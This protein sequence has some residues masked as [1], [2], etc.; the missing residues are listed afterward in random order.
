MVRSGKRRAPLWARLGVAAGCLLLIPAGGTLVAERAVRAGT[1]GPVN[2]LLVGIDPRDEHTAPLADTIIVAHIPANRQGAYLFSLP[3]DLVVH[4]P[5][6]ATN[7]T[8]AQ[9]AKINAAMAL[10][11]RTGDRRYSAAQGFELLART[12]GGV[13][14][15]PRFDAGAILNF[16]GFK[17]V[18]ETMG[19]VKVAVD[20]DV[21]S[22]HRKPDGTPRDRLPQCPVH[23]DCLRP[24]TGPQ[25]TYPKSTSPVRLKGWEALDFV[26]QR[27]GLPRSDYDRQRH[28]RQFVRAMAK[29]LRWSLRSDPGYLLK[30]T[31]SAGSSF[32]FVG[33]GRTA[34]DWAA[35]LND[36]RVREM[37]TIGLP[38]GPLFED[39]RY[40]G[41]QFPP[42][43]G[44]FF[45]A[46]AQDRIAPFLVDHPG[47]VSVDS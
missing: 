43:V 36:L 29:K 12:V 32:T 26:R 19:G 41:E 38:G 9:R 10:G 31:A 45:A 14:G 24:Y 8:V 18:V 34:V 6:F 42:A 35:E 16:G 13:T 21:V 3:R 28:Q 2:I 39:G 44:P 17:K 20:Q 15:I 47:L 4:I 11:S 37:T 22:E 33:G 5:A 27:Y 7:G 46:V 1:T 40:R 23:S 30:V 25:K